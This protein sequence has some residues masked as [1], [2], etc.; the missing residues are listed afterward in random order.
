MRTNPQGV[1][2]VLFHRCPVG[3]EVFVE[4]IAAQQESMVGL[5]RFDGAAERVGNTC[6]L[7][8]LFRRKFVEVFVERITGIDSILNAIQPGQEK[9]RKCEIWISG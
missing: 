3:D 9:R 1:V 2:I 6:D 4:D 7:G 8:Q 5:E